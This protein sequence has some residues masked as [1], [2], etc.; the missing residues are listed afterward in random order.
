MVYEVVEYGCLRF[1]LL[2]RFS[3]WGAHDATTNDDV[4]LPPLKG[5][6]TDASL[7][8]RNRED[9]AVFSADAGLT[10]ASAHNQV[11]IKTP[12]Q[13]YFMDVNNLTT[14]PLDKHVI[15]GD[16][17]WG[18]TSQGVHYSKDGVW[19]LHGLWACKCDGA[20]GLKCNQPDP[21]LI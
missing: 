11:Q 12:V 13:S 19:E 2:F 5:L 8:G 18:V 14:E 4:A 3:R 7:Y 17:E 1:V 20:C 16:V 10:W 9:V 15:H 21:N 6:G